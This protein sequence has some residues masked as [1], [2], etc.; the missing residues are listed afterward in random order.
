MIGKYAHPI[1]GGGK[2]LLRDGYTI[3]GKPPDRGEIH[4]LGN[5]A[6]DV[7]WGKKG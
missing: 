6:G 1:A 5:A 2:W 3:I 7:E 4:A